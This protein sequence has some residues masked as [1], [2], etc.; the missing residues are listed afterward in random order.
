[1]RKENSLPPTICE[2]FFETDAASLVQ[3]IAFAV[4]KLLHS[5]LQFFTKMAIQQSR[6]RKSG[7]HYVCKQIDSWI[8]LEISGQEQTIISEAGKS[9]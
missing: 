6:C 3:R 5:G 8:M 4:V 7:K 9:V 1:V 2:F